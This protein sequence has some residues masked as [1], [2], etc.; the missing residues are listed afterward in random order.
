MG[1]RIFIIILIIT[2]TLGYAVFQSLQLDKKLADQV[3]LEKNS[4]LSK[5]PDVKLKV[6]G[7]NNNLSLVELSKRHNL[8]IHFWAT[9]CGPCEKEFPKLI[10]LTEQFK[11]NNSIKFVLVSVSDNL[12]SIEKFL[13][14]YGKGSDNVLLLLDNE[15]ISQKD[16]GTYKLPETYLFS[17]DGSLIKRFSGPQE[18]QTDYFIDLVKNLK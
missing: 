14:K 12:K 15:N 17:K 8:M 1:N 6:Y 16:F 2:A 9:W 4:V 3:V 18:W 5:I 13:A 11:N 10:S 7:E